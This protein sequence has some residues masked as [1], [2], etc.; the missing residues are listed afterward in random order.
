MRGWRLILDRYESPAKT[1]GQVILT[2]ILALLKILM[3][4]L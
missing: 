4:L 3:R 1:R 2:E